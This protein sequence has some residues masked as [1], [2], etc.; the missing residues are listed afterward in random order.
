[1]NNQQHTISLGFPIEK[2][3]EAKGRGTMQS[4]SPTLLIETEK[5]IIS[6]K[7]TNVFVSPSGDK[8]IV[9]AKPDVTYKPKQTVVIMSKFVIKSLREAHSAPQ[10][11][12]SSNSPRYSEE[13]ARKWG[14]KS[15][16]Q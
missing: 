15:S 7:A 2:L 14:I 6:D 11:K 10:V 9:I 16:G 5:T 8:F 12:V 1:M 4:V 3:V 13:F